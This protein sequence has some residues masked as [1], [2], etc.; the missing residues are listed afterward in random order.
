MVFIDQT[1]EQS[2]TKYG[3]LFVNIS[4]IAAQYH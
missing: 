3:I 4:D 2:F 1:F